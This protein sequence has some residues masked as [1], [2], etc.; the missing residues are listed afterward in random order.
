[1]REMISERRKSDSEG[2]SD[3]FTNL[4]NGT[5]QD[6]QERA[7]NQLSDDDLMGMYLHNFHCFLGNLFITPK[8][9]SLPSY[10]PVCV[11]IFN[12]IFHFV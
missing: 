1:M 11:Y 3:L 7:D 5:S 12:T 2:N 6:P 4:I 10:L 9:T 8:E